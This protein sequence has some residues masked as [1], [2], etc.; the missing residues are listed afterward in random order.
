MSRKSRQ[1][2]GRTLLQKA[3]PTWLAWPMLIVSLFL[4]AVACLSPLLST[5]PPF[6]DTMPVS[7]RLQKA[8]ASYVRHHLHAIQLDFIDYDSLMISSKIAYPALLE[9]LEKAPAQTILDMRV[10]GKNILALSIDG[11][12]IFSYE[13][14]CEAIAFDNR[15]GIPVGIFAFSMAAYAAWSLF[16][17]WKY[18]RLT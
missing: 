5:P 17:R 2:K 11:D 12:P 13:A 9:K 6:E 1:K 7:A 16:I 10:D 18:R 3:F 4:G 15:M 14:A 8:Q